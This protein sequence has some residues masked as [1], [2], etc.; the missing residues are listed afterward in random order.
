M[1]HVHPEDVAKC[2]IPHDQQSVLG[3]ILP[4][5]PRDSMSRI[6]SEVQSEGK[7]S[8]PS[9]VSET[10]T[11]S[12]VR[13]VHHSLSRNDSSS[14]GSIYEFPMADLAELA[15]AGVIK[16][17]TDS[18]GRQS[19]ETE[20]RLKSKNGDYRWHLVRCVEVENITLGSGDGSWFGACTDIH[21][22]K[23]ALKL[24]IY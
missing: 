16:I 22:H 17:T 1:D 7:S 6:P 3:Q 20:V 13:G 19:Y 21:D 15:R 10:P 24:F 4:R 5:K 9:I 8:E 11:E 23:L 12:T 14:S 2:H 18:D